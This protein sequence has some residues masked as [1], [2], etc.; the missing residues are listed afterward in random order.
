MTWF[1]NMHHG[2]YKC[3]KHGE[4]PRDCK[5]CHG[6]LCRWCFQKVERTT[7]TIYAESTEGAEGDAESADGADEF[8]AQF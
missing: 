6:K 3:P 1:N 4:A 5:T 2:Y 8:W 7:W